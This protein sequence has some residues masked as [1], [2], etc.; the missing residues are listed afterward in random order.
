MRQRHVQRQW[1]CSISGTVHGQVE[2]G[3]EKRDLVKNVADVP[4]VGGFS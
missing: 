4:Q 3:F 2:Q 1:E